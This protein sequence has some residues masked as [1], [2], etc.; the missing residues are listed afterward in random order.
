MDGRPCPVLQTPTLDTP[1]PARKNHSSSGR[2]AEAQPHALD[3]ETEAEARMPVRST[4]GPGLPV[5]VFEGH[6]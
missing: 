4:A 3:E 6:V 5:S 2:H 1:G